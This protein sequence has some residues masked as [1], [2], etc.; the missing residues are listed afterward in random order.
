MVRPMEFSMSSTLRDRTARSRV[1]EY[2]SQHGS[3]QD[4]SGRATA[5]LKDA[6][7]YEGSAVAFIQ[8]VA[9][10]DKAGE[11]R[12]EIRGKR[13]Y[14]IAATE[15][16]AAPARHA[17][18][19]DTTAQRDLAGSRLDI[20]YDELARALLREVWSMAAANSPYA[21]TSPTANT[22]LD[23]VR[24]ERDRLLAER[25]DYARRLQLARQQLSAL[26]A[27]SV[28]VAPAQDLELGGTGLGRVERAS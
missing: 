2:L 21:T 11:I 15:S 19:R 24:T 17:V 26:I 7:G 1:R 3:I 27:G 12:R 22:S 8:L 18:R 9:A 28:P 5:L 25:D 16:G 20:D 23:A 10:M 6:V 4:P 13:T 14:G